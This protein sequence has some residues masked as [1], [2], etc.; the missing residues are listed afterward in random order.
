[1][2]YAQD[3]VA[4]VFLALSIS[5]FQ[6]C[7]RFKSATRLQGLGL[8]PSSLRTMSASQ[9]NNDTRA[10]LETGVVLFPPPPISST[11]QVELRIRLKNTAAITRR[12]LVSLITTRAG[13]APSN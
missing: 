6:N 7:A 9:V 11:A 3:L 13:G 4:L 5:C 12:F 1:M 8:S 10:Q 2:G